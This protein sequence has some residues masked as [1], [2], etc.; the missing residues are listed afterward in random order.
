MKYFATRSGF[1]LVEAIIVSAVFVL[2]FTGL[3]TSVVYVMDVVT[4]AR[5]RLSALS[6]AVDRSEYI[7]SLPY[8]SVGTI[9]GIP[10]GLIPQTSTTSLNGYTLYERVLVQYVDDDADG[11]GGADSNGILADY[12]QVKVELSWNITGATSTVFLITNIV[13]RSIE[14]TVG[15]G[16]IRVNVIDAYAA[17]L[18]GASVRLLNTTGTSTID[19]TKATDATGVALFAGAPANSN[20]Q[21][22]VTKAG[23]STDQTYLATTSNPNPNPPPLSVLEADVSTMNFQIDRLSDLVVKTYADFGELDQLEMFTDTSGIATSTGTQVS[24]GEL[25]L[26]DT[27]GVFVPSGTAYLTAL[28]PTPLERW[29]VVSVLADRPTDT[30]I[31]TRFYTGSTTPYTLIPEA[32]LPGN[33]SGFTARVID[34]RTL[35][36]ATYP[37]ITVGLSLETTNTAITPEVYEVRTYYRGASTLRAGVSFSLRGSK[38]IGDNAG[39]PVYKFSTTGTTNGSA[40]M[41]YSDIEWGTHTLT[42]N[43]YDTRTIC[44]GNPLNLDPGETLLLETETVSASANH[45]RVAVVDSAGLPMVGATVELDRGAL[46]LTATTGSCGQAFFSSGS[47]ADASDYTLTVTAPGFNA[48]VVDP[49][50][51]SGS[52]VVPVTLTEI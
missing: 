31:R 49:L 10:N 37:E 33:A 34:L 21:I 40:E 45:A 23:Y 25:R 4:N 32:D 41:M 18:P 47:I 42:L 11:V 27:A 29:E 9:A 43:S 28:A 24:S 52:T 3:I 1:S 36:V 44:P 7:R 39:V 14:T 26:F 2:F 15:G 38:V 12:K 51:I 16:T 17:P 13:P 20:Y 5:V 19:V 6:L 50:T 48:A 22:F 30:T 8:D 46:S 35:P